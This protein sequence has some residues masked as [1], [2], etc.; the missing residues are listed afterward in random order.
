MSHLGL[1]LIEIIYLTAFL[2]IALY[3]YNSLILSILYLLK[4]KDSPKLEV[5]S[6]SFNI[7]KVTIQLPIFNE[8]YMVE[9][10]LFAITNLDYPADKLQIQVL[11]DSTDNTAQL[12]SNLVDYYQMRGINIVYVHR[13]DRSGFKAGALDFGLKTATGEFIGIFDADFLPPPDWLKRI[14]PYFQNRNLGCVQTRWGHLNANYSSFTRALALAIDGHF[15]VE[16]TARARTELFMNFNGTAGLWRRSCIE[17][18][19][20]WKAD[21]LTE[22]F[23]LSYR[24]QM[25]GWKFEYLPEIVVPAELPIDVESFKRQQYRW[26]K[27]SFQTVRKLLPVLFT[28]DQPVYVRFMG[29]LHITAYIA[30]LLMVV[31]LLLA[32]PV[33]LYAPQILKVFPLTMLA[34]FG[35]PLLY[36]LSRSEAAPHWYDRLRLIPLLVIIGFGTSLNNGIAVLAGLFSRKT[37]T[38]V[39]TPKLNIY[40]HQQ[41]MDKNY[42]FRIS[43]IVWGEICLALYALTT[44]VILTPS[45]GITGVAWVGVYACSY[46]YIV[47][48]NLLQQWQANHPRQKVTSKLVNL[49]Q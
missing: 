24:A 21:S 14:I 46:I 30:Q 38:F 22:D 20:G 27:G 33:S 43:P 44:I 7:P 34:S 28:S 39:R 15:V 6:L 4:R 47:G 9:R 3:G 23:D 18:A 1:I 26:A 41:V 32:L 19:G 11:D 45:Q 13:S 31:L 48:L 25:K 12:T 10:L 5:S 37:G 42:R 8:K 40:E 16:Q 35:P 49:N 2:S 17:D 36:L 29:M